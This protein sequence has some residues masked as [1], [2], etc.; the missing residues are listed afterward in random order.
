MSL[1]V[2]AAIPD[3][4]FMGDGLAGLWTVGRAS[5]SYFLA[6]LRRG[7]SSGCAVN[8][9]SPS[10]HLLLERL[11]EGLFF[12]RQLERACSGLSPALPSTLNN[13]FEHLFRHHAQGMG[14]LPVHPSYLGHPGV[15]AQ[16][17]QQPPDG[18]VFL[19]PRK[20]VSS[21]ESLSDFRRW[22]PS[23]AVWKS[24]VPRGVKNCPSY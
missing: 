14:F 22:R 2:E 5:V 6:D 4:G 20:N 11:E 15:L 21:M 17:L 13:C 3:N 24:R 1:A 23:N 7:I 9:S 19:P 10:F 12:E 16:F 18:K 8:A